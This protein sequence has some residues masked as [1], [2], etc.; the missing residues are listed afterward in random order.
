[1]LGIGIFSL[2]LA[3][4]AYMILRDKP[5]DKGLLTPDELAGEVV[6]AKTVIKTIEEKVSIKTVLSMPILW[7]IGLLSLGVNSSSQTFG[8]MWEGIYLASV[9]GFD[10]TAIGGILVWYAWG[11]VIGCFASGPIVRMFGSQKTMLAGT[12]AFLINWLFI[13]IQPG[14]MGIPGLQVFNFFMGSLQMV[15]IST[16]FIFIREVIPVSR[17]GTA[18]GIVN[19]FAWILGAGIF[20]QLWGFII[21]SISKGV[22]PYP[23]EAFQV[24]LWVQMIMITVGVLCAFYIWRK[25]NNTQQNA[26]TNVEV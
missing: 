26:T 6:A 13:A 19:S 23:L 25:Y 16:T 2:V 21:N 1:M 4:I 17:L 7:L 11:L 15:V 22:Q 12:I 5:A 18:M 10:K 9:F 14:S 8:S 20:Q 24:A 3:I